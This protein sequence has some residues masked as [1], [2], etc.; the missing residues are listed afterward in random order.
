MK[1]NSTSKS[2]NSVKP[3]KYSSTRPAV[4]KGGLKKD[5]VSF[6][7]IKGAISHQM[8]VLGQKGFF[9]EFFIID[10]ISMITP[11]III[12]LGRDKE[13]TGKTNYKAGLEEAGRELISGPS[14]FLIPMGIFEAVKHFTPAS[15]ITAGSAKGLFDTM[16]SVVG[17]K[18]YVESL[19][20]KEELSKKISNELFKSAFSEYSF[21]GKDS[22]SDKFTELLNREGVKG[23]DAH[24]A[25]AEELEK[26]V[27]EI[28]N[29]NVN[30]KA[31]TD[32]HKIKVG[33]AEVTPKHLIEDFKNFKKDVITRFVDKSEKSLKEI[34][35]SRKNIRTSAAILSF[36]AVG[37]FLLYLPRLYQRGKI[38]PAD[39][40][41]KR[42]RAEVEKGG[43][44]ES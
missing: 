19:G 13:K 25:H 7:S 14:M 35:D 41:A 26:L 8:D 42:A 18:P 1:I 34:Q 17:E 32:A 28:K 9:A 5:E 12:G 22:Y 31:A 29:K 43:V 27:T 24:K 16:K 11:R 20:D 4:L 40:S 23:R 21:K 37:G 3:L 30:D 38:S 10:A 15:K 33:E 36:L 2:D 6:G 44:S 39:E